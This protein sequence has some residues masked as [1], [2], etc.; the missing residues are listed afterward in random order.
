MY[1]DMFIINLTNNKMLL[2][3]LYSLNKS[4]LSAFLNQNILF[5]NLSSMYVYHHKLSLAFSGINKID[6]LIITL[7]MIEELKV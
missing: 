7:H 6:F 2:N 4:L 1:K 3:D 5:F